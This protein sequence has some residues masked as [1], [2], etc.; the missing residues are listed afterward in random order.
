[1]RWERLR[2][3]W[4]WGCRRRLPAG[5]GGR[6]A[7]EAERA[8]FAAAWRSGNRCAAEKLQE[9]KNLIVNGV[10]P[11]ADV[12]LSRPQNEVVVDFAGQEGLVYGFVHFQEEIAESAVDD[13]GQVAVFDFSQLVDDGVLVPYF[14]M[15]AALAQVF[16]HVPAV[17]EG[18]DVESA[19]HAAAGAEDVLVA[20]GQ[21][22]G[23]VPAHAESGYGAVVAVGAGGV[24]AVNV[25]HEFLG[26]EGFVARTFDDG[27]VPVPAVGAVGAHNDE[28]LAVG[29]LRQTGL[30][31]APRLE[32]AAVSVEQI[33]HRAARGFGR[34]VGADDEYADVLVHA[35]T[36]DGQCVGVGGLCAGRQQEKEGA[37]ESE[38]QWFHV[39][40]FWGLRVAVEG[41][42]RGKPAGCERAAGAG[43]A[44]M[45][46]TAAQ[47]L[48]A[49]ASTQRCQ[50]PWK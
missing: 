42:S 43:Q 16:F 46:S 23:T 2:E 8:D 34:S 28:A 15:T 37:E 50:M 33:E 6:R 19:A 3:R 32:V 47:W 39:F 9:E 13:N 41:K 40:F 11:V 35:G 12:V 36:V 31:D 44:R 1:M 48:T 4:A 21:P 29:R 30:D 18:A 38:C 10:V 24:E 14:G 7:G 20:D 17:G 5:D 45:L 26:H 27:A 25:V 49:P 22:E